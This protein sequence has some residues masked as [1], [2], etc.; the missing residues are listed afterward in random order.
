MHCR[1]IIQKVKK[2]AAVD[3]VETDVKLEIRVHVKELDDI[4]ARQQVESRY[5]TVAR[6]HHRESL[7]A[8]GLP[9]CEASGFGAFK[10]F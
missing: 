9:V 4:I 8:T 7:S 6:P 2:L 1:P 10:S 3:L 5:D